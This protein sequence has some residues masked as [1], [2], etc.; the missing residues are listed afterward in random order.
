MQK[1]TRKERIN[2]MNKGFKRLAWLRK[3]RIGN[4]SNED[5]LDKIALELRSEKA[6]IFLK[7]KDWEKIENVRSRDFI[8]TKGVYHDLKGKTY[9]KE[10]LLIHDY[11]FCVNVYLIDVA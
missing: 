1:L 9:M 4:D 5:I 10:N 8:D 3:D 11:G 6:L 7:N 2:A